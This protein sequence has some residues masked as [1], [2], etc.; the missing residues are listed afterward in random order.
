MIV[1]NHNYMENMNTYTCSLLVYESW[2]LFFPLSLYMLFFSQFPVECLIFKG[3]R[4]IAETFSGLEE[5]SWQHLLEHLFRT[6]PGSKSHS[7]G[8]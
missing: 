1:I 2:D 6:H 8:K 5:Y 3:F 7:P 4:I